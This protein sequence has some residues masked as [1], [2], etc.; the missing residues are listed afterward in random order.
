MWWLSEK[1]GVEITELERQV[2][3]MS[4]ANRFAERRS[5]LRQ[6]LLRFRRAS[7]TR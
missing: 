4:C 1:K 2:K 7:L 6:I 5:Y 3:A